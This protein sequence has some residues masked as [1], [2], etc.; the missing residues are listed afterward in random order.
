MRFELTEKQN[1]NVKNT[2]TQNFLFFSKKNKTLKV[3]IQVSSNTDFVSLHKNKNLGE[4]SGPLAQISC[5]SQ[6]CVGFVLTQTRVFVCLCILRWHP[7]NWPI[8]LLDWIL[9]I[10]RRN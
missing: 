1:R 10:S 7:I 2:K 4:G 9:N 6:G 8:L 5:L 3:E